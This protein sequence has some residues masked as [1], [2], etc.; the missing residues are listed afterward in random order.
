MIKWFIET[1]ILAIDNLQKEENS[2]MEHIYI[3]S[4]A[5]LLV[6]I[7]DLKLMEMMSPDELLCL[8][9]LL[10]VQ[11]SIREDGSKFCPC[12]EVL[13]KCLIDNVK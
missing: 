13:N 11:P 5:I 7:S 2:S 4:G 12:F 9:K 10:H 6:A 8:T 3:I 1:A